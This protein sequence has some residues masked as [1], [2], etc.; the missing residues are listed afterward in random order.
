MTVVPFS[1]ENFLRE[2]LSNMQLQYFPSEAQ[3]RVWN[4]V[5]DGEPTGDIVYAREDAPGRFF[6]SLQT[7]PLNVMGRCMSYRSFEEVTEQLRFYYVHCMDGRKVGAS[8]HS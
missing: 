5:V 6:V 4:I 1:D 2:E 3:E 7:A 8:A